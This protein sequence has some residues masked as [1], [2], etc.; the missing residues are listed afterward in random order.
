MCE[1]HTHFTLKAG[2]RHR[3]D[4]GECPLLG[5]KLIGAKIELASWNRVRF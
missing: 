1:V 2:C 3:A 4:F 5:D